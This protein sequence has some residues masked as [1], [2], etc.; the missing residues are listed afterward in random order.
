MC[1]RAAAGETAWRPLQE[2]NARFTMGRCAL[3]WSAELPVQSSGT[4]LVVRWDE[5]ET[6]DGRLGELVAE[7]EGLRRAERFS[8]IGSPLGSPMGLVLLVYDTSHD[9]SVIEGRVTACLEGG[10]H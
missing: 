6:V 4:V 3:E 8:P 1:F 2:V 7:V 10:A 9:P 5:P